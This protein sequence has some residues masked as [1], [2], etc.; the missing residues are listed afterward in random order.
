MIKEKTGM[1]PRQ[2]RELSTQFTKIEADLSDP[3]A[4]HIHRKTLIHEDDSN[5]FSE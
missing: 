5:T 2:L 3:R 1:D 4:S